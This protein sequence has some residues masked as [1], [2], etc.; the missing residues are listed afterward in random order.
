[1]NAYILN[2]YGRG[3]YFD[4]S[5]YDNMQGTN[6]VIPM[7]GTNQVIP[8]QGTN[9][10]IPMQ[11][12]NQVIPMQGMIGEYYVSP[13]ALLEEYDVPM[14]GMP[15]DYTADDIKAYQLAY[16]MGDD[17]ALNGLFSKVKSRIKE[18]R[19]GREAQKTE[20]RATRS[21]RRK[22]RTER[23]RTG[24]TFLDK[25]GDIGGG[26]LKNAA[27]L[28]DQAGA[29]LDDLGIPYDEEI[30]EQRA[31]RSAEAGN[32]ADDVLPPAT[33]PTTPEVPPAPGAPES[34]VMAW[35]NKRSTAEKAGIGIGIA[36]VGYL[37]YKQFSKKGKR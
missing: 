8:M 32:T 11:G 25:L 4:P 34:G 6:Q 33:E 28:A 16:M 20:R 35:W 26:I 2:G 30:L 24:G 23:I 27:G 19:A 9:Q 13:Y 5:A 14:Q 1:M 22:L 21:E 31:L 37:A 18:R 17:D 3:G 15:S 36:V 12:T 10:V 7:Q 29:E